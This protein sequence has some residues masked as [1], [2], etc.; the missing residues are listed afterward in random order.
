MTNTY[1]T[2]TFCAEAVLWAAAAV[3][4]LLLWRAGGRTGA[5]WLAAAA[6]LLAAD[7]SLCAASI[8]VTANL[9]SWSGAAGRAWATVLD[10]HLWASP[11][12]NAAA[13]ALACV[14]L[15]KLR[16]FEHAGRS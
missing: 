16:R 1:V 5:V 2:V 9:A 13:P 15:L 10:F 3:A 6:L 4:A 8:L 11:V 14:G 12:V 7:A